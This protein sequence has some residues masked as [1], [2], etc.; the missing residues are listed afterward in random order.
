LSA[1]VALL[2]GCSLAGLGD[3]ELP[4][5][6]GDRECE[7]L[8]AGLAPGACEIFRCSAATSRCALASRDDDGDGDP[9]MS[10]GGNDCDDL[11]P[12]RSTSA[13]ELCNGVDDDCDTLLDG[14]DEDDDA[15]GHAD[16][17][18]G[19]AA[20][21]DCDDR[22]PFTY[23]GATELCDGLDND[24]LL[25]GVTRAGGGRQP[26]R[27]EDVDG[28]LHAA[29]G[30]VCTAGP[31]GE[32]RF[33]PVDDCDDEAATTYGGALEACDG[34]DNDCDGTLDNVPGTT[35]A[36]STCL[37]SRVFAGYDNSCALDRFGKLVCWGTNTEGQ[38]GDVQTSDDSAIV[39]PFVAPNPVDVA[40]GGSFVCALDADGTVTCWGTSA[41]LERVLS[42]SF[43]RGASGQVAGVDRVVAL[44]AGS[45]HAC[46]VRDDGSVV[47]WGFAVFPVFDGVFTDTTFSTLA[48]VTPGIEDA[49]DIGTSSTMTC[50]IRDGG[51]VWCWGFNFDGLLGT[52]MTD[53]GPDPVP[54]ITDAT[55]LVVGDGFG[56]A[57][58]AD[59]SVWCWGGNGNGQAGCPSCGSVARMP[60]RV[61]GLDGATVEAL[62]AG[63]AHACVV[64]SDATLRCWGRTPK[65]SSARPT[66]R[67]TRPRST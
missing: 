37:P 40:V 13:T 36:G 26:E 55:D 47:C 59:G 23:I 12:A 66:E 44:A 58:R 21:G 7:P 2:A 6:T 64:A 16:L 15:D 65:D 1:L 43:S 27:A 45:T 10:C 41:V 38:L 5:C 56:C 49:I 67:A 53:N 3:L 62:V 34:I 18:A 11:D 42:S 33:F 52:G 29:A 48:R 35:T 14:P 61:G 51:A 8:N 30:T 32:M 63:G 50:V 46:A 28:D 54:G 19:L 57:L 25:N 60:V 4:R 22:D 17:C 20:V 31:M 24:C 9:P 39:V